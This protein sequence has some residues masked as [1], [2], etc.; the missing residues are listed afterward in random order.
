MMPRT[1]DSDSPVNTMD[2]WAKRDIEDA[3]FHG[4]YEHEHEHEPEP[5]RR[6]DREDG[7]RDR[8]RPF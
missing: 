3:D 5:E 7:P 6:W 1:P 2:E 4:E 8:R